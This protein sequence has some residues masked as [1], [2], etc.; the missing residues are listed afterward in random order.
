M[1]RP[2]GWGF[3]LDGEWSKPWDLLP[4]RQA[5]QQAGPFAKPREKT[6]GRPDFEERTLLS[7]GESTNFGRT[8]SEGRVRVSLLGMRYLTLIR[9]KGGHLMDLS[10]HGR[11]LQTLMRYLPLSYLSSKSIAI[12]ELTL[13]SAI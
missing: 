7:L 4:Y 12:T 6:G 3:S 9:R 8:P 11:A 2:R 10:L 13:H 1:G 5:Y